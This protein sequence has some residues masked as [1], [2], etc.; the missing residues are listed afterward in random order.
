[1][2]ACVAV[3][4][5]AAVAGVA[6]L[7]NLP[8]PSAS[9]PATQNTLRRGAHDV[10]RVLDL[11]TGAQPGLTQPADD[12]GLRW[13]SEAV[14]TPFA[15]NELIPSWNLQRVP[16]GRYSVELRVG[17]GT[18]VAWSAWYAFGPADPS[19][20]QAPTIADAMGRV[21][22]DYFVASGPCTHVQ[23]RVTS[24]SA[25]TG[26][27]APAVRRFRVCISNTLGDKRL[28]SQQ[29]AKPRRPDR[30]AFTRRLPVPFLT[31]HVVAAE[32]Q[33]N[34]CSPTSVAM[35]MGYRGAPATP[36]SVA[37]AAQDP[38]S[39]IFGNW[40][41]NVQAAFE[42][43]VPGYV[44]R[45]ADWT[46]VEATIAEGQP[47]IAS[48]RDPDGRLKGTPYGVTTGHL[49]VICGFDEKGDVLVNDPAGRDAAHGQ[50]TYDRRQFD[51]AWLGNGGVAYILEPA[52]R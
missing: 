18:P 6:A 38:R 47:I 19:H 46:E 31:Q 35:V 45:F 34:I 33:G 30:A 20:G 51:E 29:R 14:R 12:G 41:L 8:P 39:N 49:L 36:E 37:R 17:R 22:T 42:G 27:D 15:F 43:G 7:M 3:R 10:H 48:I 2:P 44:R 4:A 52:A 1:M 21:M 50:L 5:A 23:A 25:H 13:T 24:P 32:M 28:W 40:P 11:Y 9:S 16:R 26:A